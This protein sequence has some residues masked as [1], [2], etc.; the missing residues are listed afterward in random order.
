MVKTKVLVVED[1]ANVAAGTLQK[2]APL[3]SLSRL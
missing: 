1:E 3:M 2:R